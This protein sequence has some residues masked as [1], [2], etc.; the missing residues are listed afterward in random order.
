MG[1][2]SIRT[3]RLAGRLENQLREFY[4]SNGKYEG[5]YP[6]YHPDEF[7]TNFPEIKYKRWARENS[8]DAID[9]G[10][11]VEAND[12]Y[13]T[14]CLNTYTAKNTVTRFHRFP[15][16]TVTTRLLKGK[17][18]YWSKFL[19]SVSMLDPNS[20]S[21]KHSRTQRG[22][23]LEASKVAFAEL[24]MSG[25]DYVSA[26]KASHE[27]G[28]KNPNYKLSTS[29]TSKIIKLLSDPVVLKTMEESREKYLDKLRKDKAFSDENMIEMIK[30][31]MANV[32]KGSATHLNSIIPLLKIAGK[33]N[34]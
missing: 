28:Y 33:I 34:E 20:I 22:A 16:C 4:I 6:I 17:D 3:I 24:L 26:Y 29:Y 15:M 25:M 13:I 31:F 5:T 11:W 27:K 9:T 30:D 21:G 7:K 1:L 10:D 18:V 2:S 14:Q 23:G 8:Y 32:R 12:G 19:A